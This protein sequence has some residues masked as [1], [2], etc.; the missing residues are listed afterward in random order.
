MKGVVPSDYSKGMRSKEGEDVH[1]PQSH[2]NDTGIDYV[3]KDGIRTPP[4]LLKLPPLPPPHALPI[5]KPIPGP[6]P[7]QRTRLKI[8]RSRLVASDKGPAPA[9][10]EKYHIPNMCSKGFKPA[11]KKMTSKLVSS[12]Y[13]KIDSS[14]Q[15]RSLYK[16]FLKTKKK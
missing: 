15:M 11:R 6:S 13:V 5:D 16:K 1:P 2:L 4:P 9:T 12:S 7:A 14:K 10:I 8:T 3:T